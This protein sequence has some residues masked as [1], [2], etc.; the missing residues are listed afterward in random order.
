[1]I[2]RM[3]HLHLLFLCAC[4]PHLSSSWQSRCTTRELLAF[5]N[6][7][8]LQVDRIESN[9]IILLTDRE[10][11]RFLRRA[12]LDPGLEEGTV[13]RFGLPD[14]RTQVKLRQDICTLLFRVSNTKPGWCRS[15]R[16]RQ[17]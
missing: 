6:E 14:K 15:F 4:A 16:A 1:M 10:E 12:C 3:I 9:W 5:Q 7:A 13:F 2:P 17:P 11:E 8:F